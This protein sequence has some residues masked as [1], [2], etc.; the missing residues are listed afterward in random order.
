MVIVSQPKSQ[1]KSRF[2]KPSRKETMQEG[3]GMTPAT[4]SPPPPLAPHLLM[5][6]FLMLLGSAAGIRIALSIRQFL[7]W[8]AGSVS[9]AVPI[10]GVIGAVALRH[11]CGD[12]WLEL[13]LDLWEALKETVKKW[14]QEPPH[15]SDVPFHRRPFC[16]RLT[17][18]DALPVRRQGDRDESDDTS[19]E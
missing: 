6:A 1:W 7:D 2:F 18:E 10:G 9:I 17:V 16:P 5:I 13:E 15:F 19:E 11:G 14:E 8:S 4:P 3:E 12:N